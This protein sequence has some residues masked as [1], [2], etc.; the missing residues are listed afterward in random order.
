MTTTT[1]EVTI[2][3]AAVTEHDRVRYVLRTAYRQYAADL[4]GAVYLDYIED[5]LDLRPGRHRVIVLV[6]DVDG[7]TVGAATLDLG[8]RLAGIRA[9]AV[10]PDQRRA[11]LGRRLVRSCVE[12]AAQAGVR[13]LYLYAPPSPSCDG[14]MAEELGFRRAPELDGAPVVPSRLRIGTPAPAR[15]YRRNL[16]DPTPA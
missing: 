12:L 13:T 8:T 14:R 2:R 9:V 11:G 3:A 6:A 4:P 1:S 15:V 16:A 10:P 5:L 7:E